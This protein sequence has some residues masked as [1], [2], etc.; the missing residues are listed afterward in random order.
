MTEGF[1]DLWKIAKA[2]DCFSKPSMT[3]SNKGINS[4]IDFPA[5]YAR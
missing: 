4:S 1:F 2:S 5:V 3:F